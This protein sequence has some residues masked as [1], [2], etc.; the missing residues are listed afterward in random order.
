MRVLSTL[1]RWL[2]VPTRI[3]LFTEIIFCCRIDAA[4]I[5]ISFYFES[6]LNSINCMQSDNIP[7]RKIAAVD[8]LNTFI[9]SKYMFFSLELK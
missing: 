4:G 1:L 9:P 6:N 3:S 8:Q 5:V 2:D 7:Q